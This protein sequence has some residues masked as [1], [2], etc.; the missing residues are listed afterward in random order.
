MKQRGYHLI[1]RFCQD[2]FQGA[3]VKKRVPRKKIRHRNMGN[4]MDQN[5]AGI[6]GRI[7][8]IIGTMLSVLVLTTA[9]AFAVTETFDTPGTTTWTVPAGVTIITVEAWGGGGAG[10]GST[11]A[12]GGTNNARGGA[13]GGGGAYASSTLTVTPGESLTIV[14]AGPASGV[15]GATGNS[16]GPSF[17]GP[18]AN[19]T[20]ALVLAAGGSGGSGN[21]S[22]GTPAGGA[23]GTV[24]ASVGTTREAGE[25][26]GS[27]ATGNRIDSGA[28]GAGAQGGAGGAAITSGTSSGNAGTEP[29]GG[30]GGARTQRND[31][32]QPGGNGA[33]GEVQITYLAAPPDPLSDPICAVPGKDGDVSDSGVL[34]SYFEPNDGTYGPSS[35]TIG[36]S[37]RRGA[38]EDL[39]PGDLA[40]VIQMQ[41]ADIDTT[42]TADYGGDD[43]TGRGYSDPAGSCLAGQYEYVVAGPDTDNA[44]LDLSVSPLVETYIQESGTTAN[45]LTFQ[46]IRVP[47][48]NTITL[49]GDVTASYWDGNT[50]GVVVMDVVDELD[51]GGNTI[52]VLGRGFRGAGAV[53][54]TGTEDTT[55]PPDYRDASNPLIHSHKGEGIAGTPRYVN[56]YNQVTGVWERVDLGGTWGGYTNGDMARGAPGNAGGGGDNRNGTRDNGGGGGGGNGGTGGY[57]G[58]GW[59]SGGWGG[60]FGSSDFD[61]RGIGGAAFASP[62]PNR[63]VMGGG[64]G[65]GGTN[66]DGNTDPRSKGGAGGGIVIVRAGD[67]TGTG[68]VDARGA[69]GETMPIN[70]AG[71]G[72]GA[73]GSVVLMAYDG[74]LGTVMVN[75]TGGDGGDSALTGSNVAHG[76]GGGGAGGVVIRSGTATVNLSGGAN[77]ITSTDGDPVL[78]VA[79]GATSGGAGSDTVTSDSDF[80]VLPGALCSPTAVVM[81]RVDLTAVYVSEF[82]DGIGAYESGQKDLLAI[83]QTWDPVAANGLSNAGSR[84]ILQALNT[85][86][87]PDGDNTVVVF[88]WETLEE[89]GTIGFFAERLQ[90]GVWVRINQEML[91][92]LIAAPMGAQYW[93]ADPGALPDDNY[94]YRLIEVEARGTTRE[95]GPF[96]LT[97]ENALK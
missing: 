83:L 47:Q 58:Y 89:R 33:R 56:D 17:A 19:S 3:I 62:A 49:T 93:L 36:L 7:G 10:G 72:G 75:V 24:A 84:E 68:T 66:N 65:A 87:D 69:D 74:D 20:N 86:L 41:C 4:A 16:G 25:D 22:G 77:G 5:S 35:W 57:G 97:V 28:G 32:S 96:D 60:V 44:S 48:Y 91:P 38:T 42:N 15:N 53:Q 6:V 90:S 94:Q 71:G 52:D 13:G 27:G 82:L 67:M 55:D 14:V 31:D 50:G 54:W 37:N 1:N 59:K 45:R 9:G 80:L 34:N 78:G 12:G 2:P 43:G 39:K 18:D 88:R 92:G 26:G 51:W 81:G 23:G 11:T 95:Y 8:L 30:G 21:T 40:L 63:L 64:G 76:G 46:V 73:G 61:L 85:Y 79:H 29:G 70:D